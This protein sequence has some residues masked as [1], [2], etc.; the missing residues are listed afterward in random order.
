M[1]FNIYGKHK[2]GELKLILNVKGENDAVKMA[3]ELST[4]G[5]TSV[6]MVASVQDNRRRK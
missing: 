6:I 3:N 2:D 1:F 5:Y 4:Q